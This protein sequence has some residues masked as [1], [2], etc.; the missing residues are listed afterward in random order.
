MTISLR[1]DQY[2]EL[3]KL[4]T[5]VFNP[6]LN[7]MDENTFISICEKM[8]LPTGELFQL[9][10]LLDVDQETAKNVENSSLIELWYSDI[11]VGTIFAESIF[12]CNK[13]Q[14]SELVYGTSDTNHA[15]VKHF[16]DIG[17]WFIGLY[18]CGNPSHPVASFGIFWQPVASCFVLGFF[19]G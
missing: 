10:I 4:G 11:K 15:G 18:S 7:F 19:P 5:G 8:R 9:P 12:T 1:E 3:E 2:Q 14:I 13:E 17:D 16:F 6:V